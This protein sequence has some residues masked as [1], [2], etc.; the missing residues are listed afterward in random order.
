VIIT[1]IA[2]YVVALFLRRKGERVRLTAGVLFVLIIVETLLAQLVRLGDRGYWWMNWIVPIIA[3]SSIG[4]LL[5]WRTQSVIRVAVNIAL[6]LSPLGPILILQSLL[7]SP[8]DTRE[9][10][11]QEPTGMRATNPVVVI[12]FDEWSYARSVDSTGTVSTALPNFKAFAN[13]SFFFTEADAAAHRTLLSIPRM[14]YQSPGPPG[15]AEGTPWWIHRRRDMRGSSTT[16]IFARATE[17]GYTVKISGFYLPYRD[18]VGSSVFEVYAAPYWPKRKTFVGNV[19]WAFGRN[20]EMLGNP[21]FRIIGREFADSQY[22]RYWYDFNRRIEARVASQLRTLTPGEFVFAHLGPPHSPFVFGRDG[23]YLPDQAKARVE[24]D[25]SKYLLHLEYADVVLGRLLASLRVSGNYDSA[26][27]VVTSDH[28]W[29]SEPDSQI[30]AR[31]RVTHVPLAVKWPGQLKGAIV[32]T[33]VCLSGLEKII[34]AD[35]SSGAG[36]IG[37]AAA[38]SCSRDNNVYQGAPS[39]STSSSDLPDRTQVNSESDRADS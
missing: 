12:L 28:S 29:K 17:R 32:R 18:L 6:C 23:S 2:L 19:V 16:N 1:A 9:K 15:E 33:P 8:I 36:E 39:E 21:L 11:A 3:F 35:V 34:N 37:Q 26:L 13:S 7:W 14:I 4:I 27:I 5:L 31:G 24:A 25:S 10:V 22:N 30:R 38:L 20:L